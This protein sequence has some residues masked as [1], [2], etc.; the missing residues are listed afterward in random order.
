M[1]RL[2]YCVYNQTSECFLSL[3][4]MP[5]E[6]I[7]AR[8]KGVRGRLGQHFDEGAWIVR[9]R[10]IHTVSI[11]SARDLIYLDGNH[12]VLSV[13]ESFPSLRFAPYRQDA[14]SI[15]ALPVRTIRSSQTQ[16]GNQLVICVAD[17]MEFRLRSMSS[18]GLM[19]SG[20]MSV[21]SAPVVAK[22]WFPRGVSQDR[23]DI[24]RKCW[25][26]LVAYDAAGGS[27]PVHGIRDISSTGLYLITKER[28]PL[29]AHVRMSLQRTDA[30]DDDLNAPITMELR[31]AR[32][33][34]DG[35]GLEYLQPD[36]EQAA[37]V[38]S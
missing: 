34:R 6:N 36:A 28:W 10:G 35:V 33:G 22:S 3:G 9:P 4:V 27:L 31:V 17:E 19:E 13:T 21:N 23:R 12:K 8:L 5:C 29:G 30:I 20:A 18:Q 24:M 32:W 16:P 25:P 1:D 15:L 2:Q 7:F 26:R 37:L 11:S 14:V 38:E